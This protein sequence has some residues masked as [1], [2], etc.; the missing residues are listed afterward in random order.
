MRSIYR[1]VK[2][3]GKVLALVALGGLSLVSCN[4]NDDNN[5]FEEDPIVRVDKA[6]A[7]FKRHLVEESPNGWFMSFRPDGGKYIGEFNVWFEF[8]DDW[9]VNIKSDLDRGNLAVEKSEFNF[10]MLRTFALS[11]PYGNKIHEFTAFDPANLRTDI[12]F[13]F[14][15]YLENGD[16][17]TIGF[18]SEQKVVFRQ[19]TAEEKA[20]V[21]PEMWQAYDR[22][23]ATTTMNVTYGNRTHRMQYTPYVNQN[24]NSEFVGLF[25]RMATI[26]PHD[27]IGSI[28]A[29]NS[30]TFAAD[31]NGEIITLKPA[32]EMPD[33]SL[34]KEL[35]WTGSAFIGSSDTGT[36]IVTIR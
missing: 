20:F 33:G 14:N 1:N 36:G 25:Y 11:F 17:E 28:S 24:Q 22:L 19:A 34:V 27:Q 23:Q 4:N 31:R 21:F 15:N 32:L 12:E 26:A 29:S 10:T 6:K 35:V 16:V 5:I 7:E 2:S 3:F 18:M 9:S 30:V 13:M 8:N